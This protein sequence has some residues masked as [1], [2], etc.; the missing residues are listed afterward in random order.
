MART[1]KGDYIPLSKDDVR[2]AVEVPEKKMKE[3]VKIEKKGGIKVLSQAKEKKEKSLVKD[4]YILIITEKPQ[5]ALKIANA[6]GS[7]KNYM[8]DGVP[9]YE[10][11][12]NGKKIIIACAVGHLLNLR[13][14]EKGSKWPVFDIEWRPN[15]EDKKQDWSRKYYNALKKL[16]QGAENFINACDYDVEGEVIGW[17]ILRFIC[18]TNKAMRMKFSSLTKEELEYAYKNLEKN[19]NWGHAYAGETRHYLDWFYGI[20]LSRALM[21]S[22]K[23]AGSFR[24]MSIGRVQG[25]SLNILVHREKEINAFKPSP[26]WQVFLTVNDGKNTEKVKYNKDIIDKRELKKFESLQ[27]KS[28]AA[29]TIKKE[30]TL[31]PLHPFDLTTL[32]T[33]AYKYNRT[34]PSKTLSI[35]QQLYLEGLISYPRT[36]SQKIPEAIKPLKIIENLKKHYSFTK[37]VAKKV[38][39]EGSKSDPAHPSIYPTGDFPKKLTLEQKKL[40]EL[41][42]KRFVACFC[43]DAVIESHTLEVIYNDYKFIAR[44]ARILKKGWIDVYPHQI[45]ESDIIPMNGKVKIDDVAADEKMTMPPKRY[46]PASLVSELAKR[47]LGTKATRAAIIETLYERSYIKGQSIEATPLGMSIIDTLNKYSPIIIDEELTREFEKETDM[48]TSLKK[49]FE[50]K[51]KK[52]IEDAKKVVVKISSDFKKHEEGIGKELIKATDILRKEEQEENTLMQ[53]PACKKGNLRITYSPK[54]KKHFIACSSYPDCKQTFNIPHT[55]FVKKTDKFC[56]ECNFRKLI[57]LQKGKRPWIFC[58][59]PKCPVNKKYFESHQ[60]TQKNESSIQIDNKTL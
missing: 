10:V 26:Y 27:G 20:N 38:P 23:K 60:Y 57:R 41:I 58:F 1:L 45:L 6:L 50:K 13:Q 59:N 49:D 19:L 30:Q 3:I 2:F 22:I 40:Y 12:R 39:V 48:I 8:I 33:E 32:Q 53:C 46:T 17:N 56:E 47:N 42:V 54:N 4:R 5:A 9:Y 34:T 24:I 51:E 31:P 14:S 21:D 44:G 15:F 35:A 25:P 16:S 43:D 18:G 36:S 55:G 52:I 29:Q 28:A 37:N 7:P 11:N